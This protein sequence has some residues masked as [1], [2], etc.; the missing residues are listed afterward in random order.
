MTVATVHEDDLSANPLDV[1]EQFV[2]AN[3]WTFERHSSEEIAVEVPGRWC[4][5]GLYFAWREDVGAMHVSCAVNLKAT[6]EHRP[7]LLELL[8]QIN[9][10][11]LLGHFGLWSG[12]DLVVFRHA[13]LLHEAEAIGFDLVEELVDIALYECERFYPS[14][15]FVLVDGRDVEDALTAALL[16][17]VGEA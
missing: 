12:E 16:E 1:V 4:D 2:L 11:L 15:H 13:L 14:F 6:A 8:V 5:Y 9:E 3:D 7:A 10:Q 17:T